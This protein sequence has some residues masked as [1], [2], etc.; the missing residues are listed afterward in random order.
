MQDNVRMS[1]WDERCALKMQRLK[2]PVIWGI[3]Y[4]IHISSFSELSAG[5]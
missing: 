4:N 3:V 1:V 5:F 2:Q